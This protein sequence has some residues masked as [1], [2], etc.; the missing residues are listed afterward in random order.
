VQDTLYLFG[1]FDGTN[2]NNEVWAMT[3]DGVWSQMVFDKI[4]SMRY[5]LLL[6]PASCA[7]FD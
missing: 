6:A 1:G 7:S 5:A 2:C 4:W 3:V